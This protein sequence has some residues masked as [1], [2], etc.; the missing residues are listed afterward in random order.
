MLFSIAGIVSTFL[1]WV[2]YPIVKSSL[3]GYVGDGWVSAFLFCIPLTTA[4]FS[5][6]KK[7]E[8][9]IILIINL[10]A[11]SILSLI[12]YSG[13]MTFIEEKEN[14]V[15]QDSLIAA[16]FAGHKLDYGYYLL[17]ASSWA[18]LWVVLSQFV[19][20]NKYVNLNYKKYTSAIG[21]LPA[22]ILFL[23]ILFMDM[24]PFQGLGSSDI[25]QEEF[26][27]MMSEELTRM[28]KFLNEGQ[29]DSFV[30]Y[31]H[32]LILESLGGR[33]KVVNLLRESMNQVKSSDMKI[34]SVELE[35]ILDFKIDRNSVQAIIIQKNIQAFNGEKNVDYQRVLSYYDKISHKIY[36]LGIQ[37]KNKDEILK[38]FPYLNKEL[39]F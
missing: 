21:G 30:E 16:A 5:I 10:L 27:Q 8:G 34:E 20:R 29:I 9:K 6:L 31:N 38:I 7:E 18:G 25:D 35:D 23:G 37:D 33:Q 22:I 24:N 19:F 11:F 28:G 36:F 1:P 26:A 4:F 14:F 12:F 2:T 32:P 17:G 13:Y 15:F 39:K 3:H